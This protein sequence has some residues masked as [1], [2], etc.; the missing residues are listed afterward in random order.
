M[1]ITYILQQPM[2][3]PNLK[4]EK[5]SPVSSLPVQPTHLI[6]QEVTDL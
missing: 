5:A 2:S 3:V 1:F 4:K 6:D